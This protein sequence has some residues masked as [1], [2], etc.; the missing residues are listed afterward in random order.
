MHTT[1]ISLLE[2]LRRPDESLAWT[3]FVELYTPLL[4]SW[5]RRLGLSDSDAADL[6]QEVFAILVRKLPSFAYDAHKSFRGWLKTVAL[7]QWRAMQ[8]RKSPTP[9]ETAALEELPAP[10]AEAF[11]ESEYRAHLVR[12]AL[13]IMQAEF[14]PTTWKA[15]WE[16][17]VNGR[18]APEVAAEL[19]L[20][21]GA[22]WAA[23]FRVLRRL[24]EELDGL[25]D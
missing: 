10:D 6:V 16:C 5:A 2:R 3:R 15:C 21:V 4:T 20:T 14:Q 9:I 25:F 23:K 8:R 17:T 1:S 11:W 12:R 19:G 24:R 13:A 7:N 22:V 18:P